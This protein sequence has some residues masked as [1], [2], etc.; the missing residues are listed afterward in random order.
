MSHT[1]EGFS[2]KEPTRTD[3]KG[4]RDN[5]DSNAV[6]LLVQLIQSTLWDKTTLELNAYS[7][8]DN[9]GGR[10]LF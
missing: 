4:D 2:A 6:V 8:E 1:K 10:I 3:P 5:L 7:M 9:N